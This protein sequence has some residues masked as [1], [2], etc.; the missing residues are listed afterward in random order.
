[1][2]TTQHQIPVKKLVLSQILN[3]PVPAAQSVHAE[4]AAMRTPPA[5][6]SAS[7]PLSQ[8]GGEQVDNY[9]TFDDDDD[10][11]D[12]ATHTH[13]PDHSVTNRRAVSAANQ[14]RLTLPDALDVLSVGGGS[15]SQLNNVDDVSAR[16][17]HMVRERRQSSAQPQPHVQQQQQQQQHTA[18]VSHQ[19]MLPTFDTLEFSSSAAVVAT[20]TSR[21]A[22]SETA[23]SL[24]KRRAVAP[25]S[26]SMLKRS[27]QSARRPSTVTLQLPSPRGKSNNMMVTSSS[28]HPQQTSADMSKGVGVT[29]NLSQSSVQNGNNNTLQRSVL[30][31]QQS[32]LLRSPSRRHAAAAAAS[33]ADQLSPSVALLGVGSY[34]DTKKLALRNAELRKE[35][36][37]LKEHNRKHLMEQSAII[38]SHQR[39][40]NRSTGAS[41]ISNNSGTLGE[42]RPDEVSALLA[43]VRRDAEAVGDAIAEHSTTSEQTQE[44]IHQL[45]EDAR[46]IRND[47]T[48]ERM[49][50][51]SVQCVLRE[52]RQAYE[53]WKTVIQTE[54][55]RQ[56]D[57]RMHE[58][59]QRQMASA[60]AGDRATRSPKEVREERDSLFELTKRLDGERERMRS[61][62]QELAQGIEEAKRRAAELLLED[63]Q[64]DQRLHALREYISSARRLIT[65]QQLEELPSRSNSN[66]N[67]IMT[68]NGQAAGGVDH[69]GDTTA[70]DHVRRG[71]VASTTLAEATTTTTT[72]TTP[73]MR[74]TLR[75]IPASAASAAPTAAASSSSLDAANNNNNATREIEF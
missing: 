41:Y 24:A 23:A 45:I 25:N 54:R 14:R 56:E 18:T 75:F 30:S 55:Q 2:A 16:P 42:Y 66:T 67:I 9:T 70:A 26:P 40:L 52:R 3:S 36:R 61:T 21:L 60:S 34:Q 43:A 59:L 8:A 50:R 35:L 68:N 74:P 73:A 72:T 11:D 69:G 71:V 38:A 28:S 44:T 33:S 49:A 6:R 12:V 46:R 37:E 19:P 20:A 22:R 51:N 64:L 65:D 63:D 32:I 57:S 62:S 27:A 31:H 13:R 58:L 1:M 15:D 47:I 29:G 7:P 4:A 5:M 53:S 39:A 10:S 17:S 48:A